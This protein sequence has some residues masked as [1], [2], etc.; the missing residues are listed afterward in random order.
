[1]PADDPTRAL[2]TGS[3][4]IRERIIRLVAYRAG[5]IEGIASAIR[6]DIR[7]N[8]RKSDLMAVVV[9]Q[10]ESEVVAYLGNPGPVENTLTVH[11][12][13]VSFASEAATVDTTATVNEWSARIKRKLATG[14]ADN[15][16]EVATM[17]N[18]QRL[19]V[20][21]EFVTV[22]KPEDLGGVTL[23]TVG[24]TITYRHDFTSPYQYG[25][26]ITNFCE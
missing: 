24:V 6:W 9:P 2:P 4:S 17:G 20:T 22:S 3:V 14:V 7:T 13:V 10:D 19:A 15:W 18:V 1:M 26:A 23:A 11:V 16:T 8:Q 5:L 12:C 25:T 21:S